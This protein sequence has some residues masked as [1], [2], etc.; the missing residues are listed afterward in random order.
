MLSDFIVE[1]AKDEH[2]TPAPPDESCVHK[3]YRQ[4][5]K[6]VRKKSYLLGTQFM[7]AAH[8]MCANQWESN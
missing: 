3:G 1:L 2:N 6:S 4:Q 8:E 5:W 7:S